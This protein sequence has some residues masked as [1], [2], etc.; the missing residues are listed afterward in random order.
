MTGS[1]QIGWSAIR[2]NWT[3]LVQGAAAVMSVVATVITP[4]PTA[5][6]T[7]GIRTFRE[8]CRRCTDRHNH[9]CGYAI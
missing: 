3:T 2:K 8:F 5:A 1:Q 7:K 9:A 4:P 6:G